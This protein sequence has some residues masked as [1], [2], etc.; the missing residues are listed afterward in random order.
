MTGSLLQ[1]IDQTHE[2]LISSSDPVVISSQKVAF[3]VTTLPVEEEEK[4][5]ANEQTE[6]QSLQVT[7]Q[8]KPHLD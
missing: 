8:G 6:T 2:L 4:T 7:E 5:M 3:E 1:Q